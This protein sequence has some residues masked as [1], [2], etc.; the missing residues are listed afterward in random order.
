MVEGSLEINIKAK[1][2]KMTLSAEMICGNE[3]L[4]LFGPSGAGKTTILRSIAGLQDLQSGKIALNQNVFYCSQTKQIK[5][6]QDRHCGYVPQ[7]PSLFPHLNVQ[8]NICFALNSKNA[9]E[10]QTRLAELISLFHLEGLETS[11]V[12]TL[13][14]GQAKRVALARALASSPEVLLL[15]EPFSALDDELR[16]ELS[17]EIKNIQ[18]RLNIPLL[19]VT[20]SKQEAL[21]VADRVALVDNGRVSKIGPPQEILLNSQNESAG[22]SF[23]W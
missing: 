5:S 15:D 3:I 21:S 23:S 19:L 14:G 18:R 9:A 22:Y 6:P 13:S 2:G 10:K 1:L 4:V 8:E 20:H 7:N 11:A 12:N 17:S 16:V